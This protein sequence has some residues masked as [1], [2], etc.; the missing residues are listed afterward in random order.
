MRLPRLG[1]RDLILVLYVRLFDLRFWFC[2]FP[3]SFGV[4]EGL[5]IVIVALPGLFSYLFCTTAG[6]SRF[7]NGLCERVYAV[8]E[9]MFTKLDEQ[10]GEDSK[11]LLCWANI[12]ENCFQM[13]NRFSSHQLVFGTNPNL[14]GIMTDILPADYGTT[15]SEKLSKFLADDGTITREKLSKHLKTLRVPRKAHTDTEANKKIKEALRTKVRAAE[16]NI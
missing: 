8:I 2:L 12:A 5:R 16:Q 9:T 13:W 7:K 6:K 10:Y 14:P 15:T 3:L 1:K 4:W 11:T